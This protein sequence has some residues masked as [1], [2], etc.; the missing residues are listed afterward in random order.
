MKERCVIEGDGRLV[1]DAE[2][3]YRSRTENALPFSFPETWIMPMVFPLVL[4]GT[5]T[6][7]GDPSACWP[8]NPEGLAG[9][10]DLPQQTVPGS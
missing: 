4:I 5:A 8:D 6:P 3:R 7:V 1:G 10:H 2:S 9:L